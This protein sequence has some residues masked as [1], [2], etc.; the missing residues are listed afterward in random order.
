M[1]LPLYLAIFLSLLIA[2]C[3][4]LHFDKKRYS[5]GYHVS[6]NKKVSNRVIVKPES[7]LQIEDQSSIFKNQ[8]KTSGIADNIELI[9]IQSSELKENDS[10]LYLSEKTKVEKLD[11]EKVF[12]LT[13]IET[14]VNEK[15]NRSPISSA[16]SQETSNSSNSLLF[17]LFTLST[18]F[19]LLF[20][21]KRKVSKWAVNND[22]IARLAI[23]ISLK[24]IELEGSI[25]KCPVNL[26]LLKSKALDHIP[27]GTYVYMHVLF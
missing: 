27:R 26:V 13:N 4:S 2:G 21:K 11:L 8:E 6:S 15:I 5:R 20:F 23:A 10:V 12:Q 22:T 1:K 25:S 17:F 19:G 16:I 3:S 14:V 9:Y 7:E 18:P 24:I